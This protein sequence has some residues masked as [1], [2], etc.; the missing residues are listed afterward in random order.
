MFQHKIP[1]RECYI[2]MAIVISAVVWMALFDEVVGH[3]MEGFRKVFEESPGMKIH[4]M[5]LPEQVKRSRILGGAGTHAAI[6]VVNFSL[7]NGIPE[8]V[9]CQ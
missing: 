1:E 7:E 8:V 2:G 3:D 9:L 5:V 4:G 6:R